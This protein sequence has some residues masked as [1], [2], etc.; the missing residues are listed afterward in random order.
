MV[1]EVT[2]SELQETRKRVS[3]LSVWPFPTTLSAKTGQSFTQA[4]V[5]SHYFVKESARQTMRK[6]LWNN[7]LRMANRKER[8]S[9]R[10]DH[11]LELIL[12]TLPRKCEYGMLPLRPEERAGAN[13][14]RVVD[15]S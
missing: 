2:A 8:K 4:G 6:P 7:A 11:F 1:D 15:G 3:D 13:P 9:R 14:E 5:K 10:K 12:L